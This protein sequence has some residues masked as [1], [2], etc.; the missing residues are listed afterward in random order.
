MHGTSCECQ[1]KAV[2]ERF[3]SAENMLLVALNGWHGVKASDL[4][5]AELRRRLMQARAACEEQGVEVQTLWE[6]AQKLRELNEENVRRY[7]QAQSSITPILPFILR[8][9]IAWAAGGIL[10][11]AVLLEWSTLGGMFSALGAGLVA[12]AAVEGVLSE[13]FPTP[14]IRI[15]RM[16]CDLAVDVRD[17][18]PQGS[19]D[20]KDY[21]FAYMKRRRVRR[22]EPEGW[23]K[24]R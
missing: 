22:G 17:L 23:I 19:A 2:K 6:F 8:R 16:A 24:A 20:L 3:R 21:M 10:A 18:W 7:A 11:V 12:F 1:K 9:R 13:L 5:I 15:A 14:P 4:E